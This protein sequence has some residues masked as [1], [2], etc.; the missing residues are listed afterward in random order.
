MSEAQ[1]TELES[2]V[3]ENLQ[4][5][6]E[7]DSTE[8]QM[9]DEERSHLT[10]EELAAIDEDDEEGEPE[11]EAKT[12]AAVAT[13]AEQAA[14]LPEETKSNDAADQLIEVSGRLAEHNV[15]SDALMT[16][17][18]ELAEQVDD[19]DLTQGQYDVA[20]AKVDSELR[21]LDA[22]I[23]NDESLQSQITQ[24]IERGS[25]DVQA[26]YEAEFNS[27]AKAFLDK[28][29]NAVFMA[30]EAA[31]GALQTTIN[32]MAQSGMSEGL[33]P[34]QVLTQARAHVA[35]RIALPVA[36]PSKSTKP[37]SERKQPVI[38]PNLSQMPAVIANGTEGGEF[39]HLDKLSGV[40]YDAAYSKLSTLQQE[41][42][43][44]G[45]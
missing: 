11:V 15:A 21:R 19:G 7:G 3:D 14:A 13:A 45:S 26:K 32:Q 28:P 34:A 25:N 5:D 1:A 27:E 4:E 43:M 24:Q 40:A 41:R 9:T 42:Y 30:D 8:Y 18:Q 37:A 17:L 10:A 29:E 35:L 36:T 33:T 2:Q 6:G 39:A 16:K 38:P 23:A 31:R 20:R 22:K 44:N 12:I